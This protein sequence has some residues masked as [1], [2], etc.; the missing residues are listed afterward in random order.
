MDSLSMSP[1]TKLEVAIEV[2]SAKI[3]KTSK[4]GYTVND[5]KM[6]EL[7]KER[8]KMYSGD[9]QIIDKIIAE[10]GPEMK[11]DYEGME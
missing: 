4:E 5:E 3:A 1:N 8:E 7:L 10:Y 2:L 9:M 11:K 6:K